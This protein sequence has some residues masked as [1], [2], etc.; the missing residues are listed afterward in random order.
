MNLDDLIAQIPID[1]VAQQLGVSTDEA[2]QSVRAALPALL[3]GMAA[4]A[5]D[6][7]GEASLASALEQHAGDSSGGL[8][9]IFGGDES[10][11]QKIVNHVFGDKQ[12]AVVNELSSQ[13]GL[14]GGLLLKLLPLLA[15][16][17]MKWLGG[18]FKGGGMFS[19]AGAG[20]GGGSVD[21]GLPS[22]AGSSG[23]DTS[24]GGDLAKEFDKKATNAPAPDSG[25]GDPLPPPT[26]QPAD[27]SAFDPTASDPTA[28]DSAGD[29]AGA[30]QS[31][32]GGG[33]G[34]LLDSILG[35]GS[36]GGGGGGG[37]GGL[38]DSILG[39]GR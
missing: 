21:T 37:L 9:D 28:T 23:G 6:P 24:Y 18:L 13:R 19:P 39:K 32:G 38:L 1:Q 30:D 26:G 10:D 36:G 11:G 20:A 4:N 22:D 35:G 31:G 2:E 3:Q 33:L 34:G 17:L 25:S 5:S 16:L 7:A 29:S 8:F 12:D 27:P 14:S 15:P